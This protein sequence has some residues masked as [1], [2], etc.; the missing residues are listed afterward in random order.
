MMRRKRNLEFMPINRKKKITMGIWGLVRSRD[1]FETCSHL[2]IQVVAGCD[3]SE[4]M[5]ENFL[6]HN[7]RAFVTDNARE[8]LKCDMDAVLVATFCPDHYQDV[9][10]A[11]N[12]GKHVLSEVTAFHTMSNGAVMRNLMGATTN[13][14]RIQ[15]LW[16]TR[17]S[18][19]FLR[20]ELWIRLGGGGGTRNCR[21]I[22]AQ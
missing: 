22:P 18:A 14:T 2:G 9:V 6:K 11:L 5:R 15:R 8:F 1:F 12:A 19:E 16:G 7:P 21:R 3:Y 10:D 13:D 4:K 17:G 20:G